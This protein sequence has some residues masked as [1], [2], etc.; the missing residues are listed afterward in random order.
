MAFVDHVPLSARTI[1]ST[2]A[3]RL[4][5]TLRRFPRLELIAGQLSVTRTQEPRQLA[6]E[7]LGL[8]ELCVGDR[9]SNDNGETEHGA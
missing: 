5:L 1:R 8:A 3:E 9:R 7:L 6:A 4:Y 2:I